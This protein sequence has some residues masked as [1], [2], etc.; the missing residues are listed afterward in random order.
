[1]KK[2]MLFLFIIFTLSSITAQTSKDVFT[3]I[4]TKEPQGYN[5]EGNWVIFNDKYKVILIS[6][7]VNGRLN[8]PCVTL[9][10]VNNQILVEGYY[11][12][13]LKDGHWYYYNPSTALLDSVKHYVKGRLLFTK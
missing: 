7:Y 5:K 12:D 2:A 1:M 8:G 11:K 13:G 9:S 4:V 10:D 3:P 6:T